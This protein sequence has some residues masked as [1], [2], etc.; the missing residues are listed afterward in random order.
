MSVGEMRETSRRYDQKFGN[1]EEITHPSIAY[2]VRFAQLLQKAIDG[3]QAL[4]RKEIEA[5]IPDIPWED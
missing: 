5:V 3:G 2:D 1:L 4:G